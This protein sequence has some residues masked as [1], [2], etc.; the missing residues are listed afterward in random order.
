MK[1][2]KKIFGLLFIYGIIYSICFF[3]LNQ[4]NKVAGYEMIK[5][6]KYLILAGVSLIIL[7]FISV[8]TITKKNRNSE[9]KDKEHGSAKWEEEKE[10]KK[11]EDDKFENNILVS[12]NVRFSLND[13]KKNH[14]NNHLCIFGDSGAG[15]SRY[16]VKPNVLQMNASYIITDPKGEHIADEATM[17]RNNHYKVKCFDAK[18]FKGQRFNPLRYFDKIEEIDNFISILIENTSG[19][20][21][22]RATQDF[23]VKAERLWLMAMITYLKE[24]FQDEKQITIPNLSKL[25]NIC[26]ASEDEEKINK[27]D[28]LFDELREKDKNS[29]AVRQYEKYKLSAGKTAKSIM[30]SIAVRLSPWDS[31]QIADMFSDD[32]LELDK[33]GYEKTALFLIM[34]DINNTYSYLINMVISATINCLVNKADKEKKK[35][36]PI[37]VRFIIDEIANIGRIPNLERYIAVLRSRAIGIEMIWQDYSQ[38]KLVYGKAWSTIESNCGVILF[39]GGQGKETTQYVSEELL[40]KATIFVDNYNYSRNSKGFGISSTSEGEN[41]K[42]RF[43]LD[44]NEVKNIPFEQCIVKIKGLNPIIDNKIK[45]EEH[46]NY[47]LLADSNENY[48][49]DYEKEFSR[50]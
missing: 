24:T 26:T 38:G 46:Q 33:I 22:K 2:L 25:C 43:L 20:D 45:T 29:F 13:L 4:F 11:I 42:E 14:L 6:N 23:W 39:L 3:T 5:A 1:N 32:E 49:F 12:E 41:K 30:I 50:N 48:F 40:G 47:K 19:S 15:K 34:S 17:L 44:K 37:N 31:P 18:D 21:D 28:L 9:Y 35:R 8:T 10:Y 7:I 36:L 27:V 16:Y